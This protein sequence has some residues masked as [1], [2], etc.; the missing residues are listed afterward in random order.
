MVY[1]LL[2]VFFKLTRTLHNEIGTNFYKCIHECYSFSEYRIET[3]ANTLVSFE[4]RGLSKNSFE[5][6][7]YNSLE[8]SPD[9]RNE[10]HKAGFTIVSTAGGV[11]LGPTKAS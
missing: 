6:V 5:S 11:V 8:L 2:I 1:N 10:R 3:R 7:L 9:M 4:G